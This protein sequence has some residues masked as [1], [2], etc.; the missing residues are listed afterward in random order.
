[1]NGIRS[2]DFKVVIVGDSFVGKTTLL[3]KYIGV[4]DLRTDCVRHTVHKDGGNVVLQ[5][6]DTMG[7]ERYRSLTRSF[8]RGANGC[9]VCFNVAVTDSFDNVNHWLTDLG[10]YVPDGIPTV[11][12]GIDRSKLPRSGRRHDWRGLEELIPKSQIDMF[13][14]EHKL[15][16]MCVDLQSSTQIDHVFGV[17]VDLL[18][19]DR[20]RKHQ[21]MADGKTDIVNTAKYDNTDKKSCLC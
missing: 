18:L 15:Q 2:Y 4:S 16:Y 5:I 20:K 12:V 14:N 9:L 13:C 10:E 7:Q 19:A 3:K 8:Y 11:L 17:L 21:E 1:M 6:Y